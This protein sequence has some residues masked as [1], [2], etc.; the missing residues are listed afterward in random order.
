MRLLIVTQYFWPENFRVNDL[1]AGLGDRGHQ[2]TVLTGQPNYP[3]GAIFPEY[4]VDPS[5]F[6]QLGDAEILRIP[7]VARGSSKIRLVLNYLSFVLSGCSIGVFKLRGRQFDA[8]FVFQTSPITSAIPAL[9]I[10]QLKRAPVA[11]WVLDVWPD[12]LAAIGIVTSPRL[13]GMVGLLVRFI[14]RRCALI[15]VQ[16]RAFL[17]NIVRYGGAVHKVRYFPGWAEEVFDRSAVVAPPPEISNDGRSFDILF[18]GNIG[19]AQDF[20]AIIDAADLTRTMPLR[21]IIVGDGRAGAA[22]RAE[23]D[24]RGLGE[25]V[26]FL[27]RY[28]LE[29]MPGFFAGADALLVSLAA[30]PIWSMTIPGKIQSYLASGKPLLGMLDGE[31]ARVI[32]ESGAGLVGPAGNAQMLA[33]NAV[34]LMNRSLVERRQMGEAGRRF[35]DAEFDRSTLI[36]S[37]EHW[38][39]QSIEA[40]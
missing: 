9:L 4:R 35:A 34:A 25:R 31:G 27:G 14:Y 37:L 29:R 18:A 12:T 5:A 1:C 39:E 33:D 23:V 38:I 28:P 13:L 8:I 15:L 22:A 19:E 20:P 26:I 21:W 24:S 17:D 3:D 30:R 2:I 7:I 11:M 16:S 32:A 10:G 40:Y 6:R 36:G